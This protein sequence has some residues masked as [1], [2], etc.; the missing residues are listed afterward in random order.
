MSDGIMIDAALLEHA[1]ALA[2]RA[3]RGQRDK[4]GA[5]YILHPLRLLHRMATVEEMIVAVLHDVLEDSPCTA[6]RLREE[7]FPPPIVAAIEYLTRQDGET[8]D[9]FIR[10]VRDNPLARRVKMADLEDN[11]NILRLESVGQRDLDR[12]R[13]YHRAYRALA[14]P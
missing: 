3:H 1:I 14:I 2:C 9:A 13:Q 5:P 4:G 10:R 6:D 7:G 11:L 12:L 8:Y